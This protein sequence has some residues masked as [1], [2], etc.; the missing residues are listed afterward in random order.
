[1]YGYNRS[2]ILSRKSSQLS[3]E[4]LVLWQ[5]WLGKESGGGG[6]KEQAG[7]PGGAFESIPDT[8][9]CMEKRQRHRYR[10]HQV[11]ESGEA[12]NGEDQYGRVK[13]RVWGMI[14]GEGLGQVETW[15]LMNDITASQLMTATS[16]FDM[17]GM[18]EWVGFPVD[19]PMDE[20]QSPSLF[21]IISIG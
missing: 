14:G 2:F 3:R 12:G 17:N 20:R 9:Q 11:P 6:V 18:L 19:L 10:S 15:D 4:Y 16:T 1:M 13:L 5:R 8:E 21:A 7:A